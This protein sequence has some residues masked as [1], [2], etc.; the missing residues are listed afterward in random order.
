MILFFF[1]F[2]FYFLVAGGG[3][4]GGNLVDYKLDEIVH[5]MVGITD[6]K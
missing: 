1:F 4:G 3:G 5:K 2:I 6:T